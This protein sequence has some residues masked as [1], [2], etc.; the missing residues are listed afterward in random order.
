MGPL[1]LLLII[2]FP[3]CGL[4]GYYIKTK[5][6]ERIKLIEK[7]LNPDEGLNISEYQKQTNLKYGV[8]LVSLAI[9]LFVGHL[10]VISYDKLDSFITYLSM[11]LLFGGIGFLIN[12]LILRNWNAK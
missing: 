12:F 11:L 9:G 6:Q 7:G 8:L 3:V 2:A 5:N 10:L 4:I 1:L